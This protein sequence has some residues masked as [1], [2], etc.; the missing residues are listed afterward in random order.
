MCVRSTSMNMKKRGLGKGLSDMGLGALLGDLQAAPTAI[1][2][3]ESII[4]PPTHSS[5]SM[6]SFD[7]QLKKLPIDALQP[8]KYQPRKHIAADALEELANSIRTQ[9]M[10]QP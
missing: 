4:A 5:E 2:D 7:G 10:I 6:T 8:G 9:G 1:E 3:I